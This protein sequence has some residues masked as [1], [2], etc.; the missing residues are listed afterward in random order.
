MNANVIARFRLRWGYEVG[1]DYGAW[2]GNTVLQLLIA[3]LKSFS[4]FLRS[5]K[6]N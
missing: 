4:I 6:L 1:P 3:K 5:S 2:I